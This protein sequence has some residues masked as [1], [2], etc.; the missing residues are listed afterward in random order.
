MR[1]L[2]LQRFS[3]PEVFFNPAKGKWGAKA[4]SDPRGSARLL[5]AGYHDSEPEAL[6]ALDRLAEF[7]PKLKD[8]I[9]EASNYSNFSH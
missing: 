8:S 2:A 6:R 7:L 5:D 3:L 1:T 9:G 4:F